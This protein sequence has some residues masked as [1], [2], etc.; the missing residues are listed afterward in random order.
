MSCF[1]VFTAQYGHVNPC[2]WRMGGNDLR[3]FQ[4]WPL[5]PPI[6]NSSCSFFFRN[7]L[8][9]HWLKM[10]K[11]Q[12]GRNFCL[13][14][15]FPPIKNTH[16]NLMGTRNKSVLIKPWRFG[17][18]CITTTGVKGDKSARPDLD[19]LTDQPVFLSLQPLTARV[20]RQINM[21]QTN[22]NRVLNYSLSVNSYSELHT[23]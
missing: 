5:K 11:L 13:E 12:S 17:G 3:H 23:G 20:N 14:K 7:D 19:I 15:S 10:V 21:W 18:L 1:L 22:A 8:G 2:Q 9:S 16:L 4:A 6:C